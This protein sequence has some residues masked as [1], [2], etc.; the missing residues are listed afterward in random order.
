M[1]QTDK[2]QELIFNLGKELTKIVYSYVNED[3]RD[4]VDIYTVGYADGGYGADFLI[5]YNENY[6]NSIEVVASGFMNNERD[7]YA[8]LKELTEVVMETVEQF[9]VE[10]VEFP[11]LTKVAYKSTGK[12]DVDCDYDKYE[13]GAGVLFQI[14]EEEIRTGKIIEAPKA[15]SEEAVLQLTVEEQEI[16]NRGASEIALKNAQMEAYYG[17]YA[18]G[19]QWSADQTEGKVYFTNSNGTKYKADFQIIGSYSMEDLTFM[20]AHQNAS[21]YE[22]VVSL[23]KAVSEAYSEIELF[24]EEV[25]SCVPSEVQKLVQLFCGTNFEF[26]GEFNNGRIFLVYSNLEEVTQPA[27][28]KG[29]SQKKI[30]FDPAVYDP[31]AIRAGMDDALNSVSDEVRKGQS[32]KSSAIVQNK[33]GEPK[34]IWFEFKRNEETGELSTV[35]LITKPKEIV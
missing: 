19:V 1:N 34:E 8:L 14:W 3:K 28:L 23:S 13:D 12:F 4:D 9:K 2:H 30:V 6:Y 31:N 24:Q 11:T 17:V 7:M 29:K 22:N 33:S 15:H 27:P 32:F 26:S 25:I 20:W 16:V 10:E 5:G 35:Y 18:G 21:L